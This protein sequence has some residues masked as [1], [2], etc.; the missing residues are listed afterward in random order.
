MADLEEAE[1]LRAVI[2]GLLALLG[3]ALRSAADAPIPDL[4]RAPR[5]RSTRRCRS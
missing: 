5:G 2:L 3:L 1:L 4:R